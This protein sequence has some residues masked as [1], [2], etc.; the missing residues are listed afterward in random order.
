METTN[1]TPSNSPP[2]N[3]VD[4]AEIERFARI[5]E[6]WWNPDG[7]F[8]PLHRMNPVRLEFIRDRIAGHFQRDV[9]QIRPFSGLSLIDIGCGGGLVAEP[10][11][12]MGAK[13]TGID[14]TEKNIH[15]ARIHAERSGMENVEYQFTTAE[16]LAEQK[17]SFDVV[18]AL[19][20]IEHVADVPSFGQSI[21][22]LVKP[23][24]LLVVSTLNRT[25]KSW[26]L[27]IVGAEYV[28]RWLPRGTHSWKK[29]LR[30]S[31]VERCIT[32]HGLELVSQT[33]VI[34]NPLTFEWS[35]HP[36]DMEVNYMMVFRKPA[37][38]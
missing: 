2:I 10:M 13:V 5:A 11:A 18:L 34:M 38:P 16:S 12:R 6:E 31:E 35:T 9:R 14:A 24:G 27:A 15:V 30:P 36:R 7:K 33:G 17:A 28:L 21:S 19:E 8:K 22:Q 29:F 32:P 26:L 1:S 25:P 4:P 23:G 20:I 37:N 3:S